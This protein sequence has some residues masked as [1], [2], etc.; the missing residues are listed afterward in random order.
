MI[1]LPSLEHNATL[2]IKTISPEQGS[3]EE[4][5]Q[6]TQAATEKQVGE[7]NYRV[8][9]LSLQSAT[10]QRLGWSLFKETYSQI[11]E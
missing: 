2:F 10:E 6:Y 7:R 9:N 11:F 4:K 5:R 8:Q 3:A 1:D